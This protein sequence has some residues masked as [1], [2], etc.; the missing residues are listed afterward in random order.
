MAP[1]TSSTPSVGTSALINHPLYY[2][3]PKPLF[4]GLDLP[5]KQLQISHLAAIAK[6]WSTEQRALFLK[7]ANDSVNAACTRFSSW[8]VKN[9]VECMCLCYTCIMTLVLPDL[10]EMDPP[11][12]K[13][14]I[15]SAASIK[16]HAHMIL[17]LLV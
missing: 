15:W 4:S 12:P 9:Q 3:A 17:P 5:E 8:S 11:I 1:S 13:N 16:A 14:E 6:N 10:G 7:K 2:A